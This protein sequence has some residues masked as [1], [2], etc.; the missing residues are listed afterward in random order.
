MEKRVWTISFKQFWN[1]TK[2][3]SCQWRW[4]KN[5]DKDCA[6]AK[7]A[8]N[9]VSV[10][11]PWRG[12][13]DLRSMLPVT[14]WIL[15]DVEPHVLQRVRDLAVCAG[16]SALVQQLLAQRG[17]LGEAQLQKFL[18]PMLKELSDPFLLPNMRAAVDRILAAVDAK[19]EVALFG[20]YDVDGV[21]SLTLLKRVLEA[22]GL[23]PKAFLPH[24]MEEGYGVSREGL[25]RLL[26]QCQPTLL[27][28]VDCGTTSV[29]QIAWLK[30]E[31]GVDVIVFDHHETSN[32]VLPDCVAVVNP[33]L[34]DAFHYL[35]SAGVIFKLAHALMKTR[36]V[37][38]FDLREHLDI[39]ALGTVADI[40]PLVD[41]NRLL[42]QKGL[43]ILEHTKKLGLNALKTVA[44]LSGKLTSMDL[45]FRL[46]PRL[47]A[48]GRLDTAQASLDLLLATEALPAQQ[49]AQVLD[50]HNR[51]RQLL[52]HSIHLEAEKA[53]VQA[54][55]LTDPAGMVVA[56]EEWHPGVV[57]IVASRL[58]KKY[59]RP[60]FVIAINE[61]GVG[62]GSGRSVEGISLVQAIE[63]CRDLLING[64]GHDM[65]A[66]VTIEKVNLPAFR[67]RFA[68]AIAQQATEGQLEPK[69]Y[70]D[71]ETRLAE[72]DLDFL[73]S[74]DRL[75]PFGN[76]NPQPLFLAS[77]VMPGSEP[78]LLKEKHIKFDF[79]QDGT[80]RTGIWFN[81]VRESSPIN[82]PKPPWDIAFYV[83][84]NTYRGNTTVQLLVQGL[85][86][87]APVK[88]V[89]SNP[90]PHA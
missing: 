1:K 46:G 58:V 23:Q 34:G 78:R 4:A 72:L 85:R 49:L 36:K 86:T 48:S 75:Q 66:G 26:S 71:A 47:N 84:R 82:L 11:L 5:A 74:Y 22:Y 16:E 29:E 63:A 14:H 10:P 68:N 80:T 42:V 59:H 73:H 17:I 8:L 52:E 21:T 37:E 45:G 83:D 7:I 77:N 54:I 9:D 6:E 81:G 55:K 60:V 39:V 41:E 57:G 20:D 24:R 88:R 56:A 44:A 3:I 89:I 28:A 38:G 53:A 33:K 40:V 19:E 27:I 70:V 76:G 69:L 2:S 62:K 31:H 12:K 64:G 25:E 67:E 79:Y 50:G 90:P 15:R 18:N 32:G 61:E 51:A 35:C 65:A 13:F 43:E 30:A 87:S